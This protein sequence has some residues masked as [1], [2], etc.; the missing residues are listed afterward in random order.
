MYYVSN[1][2]SHYYGSGCCILLSQP[3]GAYSPRFELDTAVMRIPIVPGTDPRQS[4]GDLSGEHSFKSGLA[5]R[6]LGSTHHTC[7]GTRTVQTGGMIAHHISFTACRPWCARHC[8][9]GIRRRQHASK[10]SAA[11]YSMQLLHAM[12]ECK[13]QHICQGI[14]LTKQAISAIIGRRAAPLAAVAEAATAGWPAGQNVL[15]HRSGHC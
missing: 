1:G 8:A 9:G 6:G 14:V 4:Y 15:L 5:A 2:S 11:R 7:T 10:S 13:C 12:T 3:R